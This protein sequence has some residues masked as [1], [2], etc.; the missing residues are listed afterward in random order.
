M[1]LASLN[2]PKLKPPAGETIGK[3]GFICGL[4][5]KTTLSNAV[6]DC[7]SVRCKTDLTQI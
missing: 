7:F 4:F 5:P 6:V 3:S 2:L 1:D